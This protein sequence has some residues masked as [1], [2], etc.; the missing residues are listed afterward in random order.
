MSRPRASAISPRCSR[1]TSIRPGSWASSRCSPPWRSC[2]TRSCG[3]PRCILAAG[4]LSD[5]KLVHPL[6]LPG[7]TPQVGLARLAALQYCGTRASPSSVQSIGLN[8]A[9]FSMDARIKSAFTRVFRRAMPAH[10]E[11]RTTAISPAHIRAVR[12]VARLLDERVAVEFF[13]RRRLLDEALR[14]VE[15][16]QL[17]EPLRVDLAQL[18]LSR[19]H[20]L[21][22]HIE[23]EADRAFLSLPLWHEAHEVVRCLVRIVHDVLHAVQRRVHELAHHLRLVLDDL[24]GNRDALRHVW[25]VFVGRDHP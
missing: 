23:R 19:V 4:T 14:Q 24:I 3:R 10:D 5:S 18:L 20:Q 12:V 16:L 17:G 21:R 9:L 11:S 25:E 15:L 13:D 8:E 22:I 2:S 6:S 1:R 7:L